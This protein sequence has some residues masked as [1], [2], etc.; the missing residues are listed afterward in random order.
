[1]Q[2]GTTA[3]VPELL[4]RHRT[5]EVERA[6]HVLPDDH[7]VHVCIVVPAVGLSQDMLPD[8][9]EPKQ[10]ELQNVVLVCKNGP[11]SL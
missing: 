8:H 2:R 4:L 10:L 9:I 3:F 5:A 6:G 7:P 1:M 11:V